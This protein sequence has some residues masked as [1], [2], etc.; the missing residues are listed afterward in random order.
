M[1]I[2]VFGVLAS[3]VL[4]VLNESGKS[5][6]KIEDIAYPFAIFAGLI[7]SIVA[8]NFDFFQQIWQRATIYLVV[9]ASLI[10]VIIVSL[11]IMMPSWVYSHQASVIAQVTATTQ[12]NTSATAQAKATSVAQ[13]K[14]TATSTAQFEATATAQAKAIA[15]IQSNATATAI[16][17]H[18]PFSRTLLLADPLK[19][20]NNA[21]NWDIHPDATAPCKFTG[22]AYL[23][24]QSDKTSYQ[25][26][27]AES[28]NFSNFTYQVQ[29]QILQGDC[30]G[31][32]FRGNDANG[33]FY[34]FMVCTNGHYMFGTC[35]NNTLNQPIT[36]NT[37]SSIR[38]DRNKIN[39]IGVVARGNSLVLYV[40][41]S[42]SPIFSVIDTTYSQGH[43]GVLA[44]PINNATQVAFSN[45][46]VWKL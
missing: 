17:L 35:E 4:I 41:Q 43:I 26:C 34:Y 28:T 21:N 31:I 39:T 1:L 23:V 19:G 45:V 24:G 9:P 37:S 38:T 2:I 14:F 33:N 15:T 29:L 3:I 20:A 6:L 44:D 36:E 42:S 12:A 8:I 18:Y 30:G 22:S 46:M 40:N 13:A 32:A 7:A 11:V 5:P 16:A 25:A 10:T 27:F